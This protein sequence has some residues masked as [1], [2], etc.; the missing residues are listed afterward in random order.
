MVA[1][2][3][4]ERSDDIT[5]VY[6][7]HEDDARTALEE[8]LIAQFEAIHPDVHII[9]QVKTTSEMLDLIPRA[10]AAGQGPDLF[11]LPLESIGHLLAKGYV[12]PLEA[13]EVGYHS[14]DE[15][16]DTYVDGVFEPVSMDG[17]IYGMPLEYTNWCLYLNTKRFD[18]CALDAKKDFPR[19]WEDV[20]RLSLR[21]VER[22]GT[23]LK[24]RG[25]DFRYPYYLNF[26]VPMVEQL[27]G[28][29]V[30]EDGREAIVGESAWIEL[31][32]FM[33]EWGP[34][35]LN[36]GSP[37]YRNSRFCFVGEEATTAMALSGIYQQSRMAQS[38]KAFFEDGNWM[39]VP[40]PQFEKRKREATAC[41]YAHYL[42]V[43]SSASLAVQKASW[44]FVGFLLA[45]EEQYLLQTG[46]LMPSKRMLSSKALG[47]VPYHELFI[48]DMQKSKPAYWGPVSSAMQ[49]LLAMAVKRVML[50]GMEPAKAY[51]MLKSSAQE[52]L[53]ES[54]R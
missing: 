32:S 17:K 25:F 33:Q 9:R 3:V 50:E 31:L 39:V 45:H 41:T 23:I 38:D 21:M 5:V 29:L 53:D 28:C 46:L 47:E 48:S 15:I 13:S 22:D 6:W 37:T 51:R 26:L 54:S 8:D 36:L 1:H 44:R 35:G 14:D 42:M 10:F 34:G 7:T 12:A 2:G 18:E 11:N 43:K 40:F 30:S 24:K 49:D 52:L 4:H 19:T 20:L 16:R 27:G